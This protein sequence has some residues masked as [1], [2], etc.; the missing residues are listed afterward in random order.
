MGLE[1]LPAGA[2]EESV[3]PRVLDTHCP[4]DGSVERGE[5][6]R[7][8]TLRE[9]AEASRDGDGFCLQC[10]QQQEFL[11]PRLFLGLCVECDLQAVLPAET[12]RRGLALVDWEREDHED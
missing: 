1:G 3:S 9:I 8:Y 11:E 2:L 7:R 10:G 4:E 5:V 12:L 6:V